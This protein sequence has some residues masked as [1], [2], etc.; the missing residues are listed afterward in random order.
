VGHLGIATSNGTIHDFAGPMTVLK[1][2][3][4][5]AFG[6]PTKYWRVQPRN[7]RN[8]TG[9]PGGVLSA[10]DESIEH[11]SAEFEHKMVSVALVW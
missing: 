8:T 5:T 6:T 11:A 3:T 4:R 9:S 10:W 7:L 2:D 1:S